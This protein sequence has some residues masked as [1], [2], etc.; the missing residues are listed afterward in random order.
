MGSSPRTCRSACRA[1]TESEW[2]PSRKLPKISTAKGA[3]VLHMPLTATPVAYDIFGRD[4]RGKQ[5]DLE[6]SKVVGCGFADIQLRAVSPKSK[7]LEDL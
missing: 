3:E 1:R 6:E 4:F 5:F 7:Y 2:V